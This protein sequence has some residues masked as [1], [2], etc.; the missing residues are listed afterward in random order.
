MATPSKS[1]YNRKSAKM[2]QAEGRAVYQMQGGKDQK[3]TAKT[4]YVRKANNDVKSVLG[5]GDKNSAKP[6]AAN[7][8]S[9]PRKISGLAA[10]SIPLLRQKLS[11]K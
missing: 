8:S 4:D 3:A 5:G 1:E 7:K 11:G 2:S 10:R 9:Y 6:A